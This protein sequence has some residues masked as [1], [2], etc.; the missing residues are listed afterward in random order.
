MRHPALMPPFHPRAQKIAGK[1]N[2]TS[3]VSYSLYVTPAGSPEPAPNPRSNSIHSCSDSYIQVS[4]I[5]LERQMV[6]YF[7]L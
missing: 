3:C 7:D 2:V 1:S 6:N 5:P 4:G